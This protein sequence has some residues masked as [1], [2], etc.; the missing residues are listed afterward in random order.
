MGMVADMWTTVFSMGGTSKLHI[1]V[2]CEFSL[3]QLAACNQKK[4]G[5]LNLDGLLLHQP[6]LDR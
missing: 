4:K 2:F 1:P 5:S 3:Y 6:A